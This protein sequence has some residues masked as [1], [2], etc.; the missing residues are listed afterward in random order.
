MSQGTFKF[1][2]EEKAKKAATGEKLSPSL[3]TGGV[4][5]G[6]GTPNGRGGQSRPGQ[7][8]AP[9]AGQALQ[10]GTGGV[11]SGSAEGHGGTVAPCTLLVGGGS[12]LPPWGPCSPGVELTGSRNPEHVGTL[13]QD[14]AQS[15]T[16]HVRD[17]ED[18]PQRGT[19]P[20]AHRQRTKQTQ[21]DTLANRR[22]AILNEKS[23]RDIALNVLP[24]SW[25]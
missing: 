15:L 10:V 19:G 23:D 4:E 25:G 14:G 18:P 1:L 5:S 11:P 20:G 13:G 3:T 16:G 9:A 24:C 21:E 17:P 12:L 2:K 7:G 22:D 8:A 6:Q